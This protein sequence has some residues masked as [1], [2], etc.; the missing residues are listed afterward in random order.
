VNADI[1][2]FAHLKENVHAATS[3]QRYFA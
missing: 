3:S 2:S 1:G